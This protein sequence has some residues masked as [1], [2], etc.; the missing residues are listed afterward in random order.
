MKYQCLNC[1]KLFVYP[2]KLISVG[3]NGNHHLETAPTA[4]MH[5]ADYVITST[6]EV[7][8][9]PYCNSSDIEEYT[10][11]PLPQTVEEIANVFIYDLTTGAQTQL[12][13]LLADGYKIVNRYSKQYHLEKT[14]AK[15]TESAYTN[16]DM[17]CGYWQSSQCNEQGKHEECGKCGEGCP[18]FA[19][20]Q[21]A[22]A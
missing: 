22:K 9:C 6:V 15:P 3:L 7:H 12:D 20:L 21:E 18:I 11:A 4:F 17:L 19:K 10:P 14:K 16:P 2:A 8:V 13:R 5:P 1:D